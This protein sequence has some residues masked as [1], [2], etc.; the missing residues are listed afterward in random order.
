MS[1]LI[2]GAAGQV[3]SALAARAGDE[4]LSLPRAACDITDRSAVAR[5]V[6]APAVSIVVNCAA[7][8]AVDRAESDRQCAFAV[9]SAGAAI[10]A[11]AAA[12]RGLPLIHLSTDQVYA[13]T[14]TRPHREDE[15]PAPVNCYGA[16][17]AAGDAAVAAANPAHLILRVS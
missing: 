3:G 13:G 14:G 15:N 5:A 9:N 10:V 16:S 12:D 7:Y 8:T 4:A 2:L 1:L 6:G 17:K 11:R